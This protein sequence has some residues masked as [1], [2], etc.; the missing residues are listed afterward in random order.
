M[1][2]NLAQQAEAGKGLGFK[3][4]VATLSSSELSRRKKRYHSQSSLP[5][6]PP[7]HLPNQPEQSN[8]SGQ[9]QPADVPAPQWE[10][11]E[12]CK[13][14]HTPQPQY[15]LSLDSRTTSGPVLSVP[16]APFLPLP[17]APTFPMAMAMNCFCPIYSFMPLGPFPRAGSWEPLRPNPWACM[18]RS[19]G[20]PNA[21]KWMEQPRAPCYPASMP[22]GLFQGIGP[23]P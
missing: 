16:F 7:I 22:Q 3:R 4:E 19:E 10:I 13:R 6:T 1:E 17:P 23:F 21:Q 9:L 14:W 2:T 8:Q 18:P 15:A 20:Q 12:S 5:P 11:K